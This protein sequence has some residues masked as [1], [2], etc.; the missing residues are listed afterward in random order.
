MPKLQDDPAN[1]RAMSEAAQ[2]K[3]WFYREN[4]QDEEEIGRYGGL[5]KDCVSNGIERKEMVTR[6][7]IG[8][9]RKLRPDM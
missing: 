9:G 6:E 8:A 3:E 4:T 2:S 1:P 7:K 5:P